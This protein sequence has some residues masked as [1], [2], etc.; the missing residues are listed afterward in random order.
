MLA[1]GSTPG[2]V[3]LWD[4]DKRAKLLTLVGGSTV[5]LSPDGRLLAKDGNGIEICD[6]TT[7]KLIKRIPWSVTTSTPGVQRKIKQLEFNPSGSLLLVSS[8]GEEDLVFDVSCGKLVAPSQSHS[9]GGSRAM[10]RS[11]LAATPSI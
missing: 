10:V 6:A 8:N 9:R 1:V 3:D 7:G 2:R 11:Q 4:V 5:A